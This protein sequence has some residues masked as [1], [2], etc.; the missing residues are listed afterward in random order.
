MKI[1]CL[2]TLVALIGSTFANETVFPD[3][4]PVLSSENGELSVTLTI[5]EALYENVE[6]GLK[7]KVVGYN[8]VVVG[9]TLRVKPGDTLRITLMN[10]L[11]EEA[12]NTSVPELW[13]QYHAISDTNLHVHGLFVP[14][15]ENPTFIK[16]APGETHE[17]TINIPETHQ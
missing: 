8:G 5:G 3:A 2:T 15:Q 11:P 9:P 13:N 7:Q 6:T 1:L 17:Y 14:A 16:I 4:Q 10:E 12:C